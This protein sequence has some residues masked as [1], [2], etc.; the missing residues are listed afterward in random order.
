MISASDTSRR[1][2]HTFQSDAAENEFTDLE[3][4]AFLEEVLRS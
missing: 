1:Q 4:G 3:E 2:T